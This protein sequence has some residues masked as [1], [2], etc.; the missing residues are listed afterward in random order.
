[1]EGLL[2]IFSFLGYILGIIA[3]YLFV[4]MAIDLHFL[5]KEFEKLKRVHR[6]GEYSL[7][8]GKRIY[9]PGEK[10]Y[11]EELKTSVTVTGL[12]EN[13]LYYCEARPDKD[14]YFRKNYY[15][16]GDKLSELP[17]EGA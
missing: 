12:T 6:L 10:L 14:V 5:R 4:R 15:I 16:P 17:K 8:K 2:I 9:R 13:G 7:A 1:M 3:F 11:C